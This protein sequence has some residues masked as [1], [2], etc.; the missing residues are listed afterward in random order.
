M[1][2]T[3]DREPAKLDEAIANDERRVLAK[4]DDRP[5]GPHPVVA[6]PASS[7]ALLGRFVMP[8]DGRRVTALVARMRDRGH[9]T[10][11]ARHAIVA[12]GALRFAIVARGQ[13]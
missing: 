2:Q 7:R 13:S 6:A 11:V 1:R 3:T 4:A 8:R 5:S 10:I 9:V 12:T